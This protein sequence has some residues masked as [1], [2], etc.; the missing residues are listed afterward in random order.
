MRAKESFDRATV[1]NIHNVLYHEIFFELL[2]QVKQAY[3]KQSDE[4][5][6]LEKLL[7]AAVVLGLPDVQGDIIRKMMQRIVEIYQQKSKYYGEQ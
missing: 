5:S 6:A 3:S 7:E 2:S 1:R 4:L